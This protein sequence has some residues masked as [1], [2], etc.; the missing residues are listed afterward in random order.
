MPIS[1]NSVAAASACASGRSEA[2]H[3]IVF[4]RMRSVVSLRSSEVVLH[5]CA[6]DGDDDLAERTYE[7][8]RPVGVTIL[9]VLMWIQAILGMVSGVVFLLLR[10]NA[11]LRHQT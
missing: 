8:H 4:E 6:V 2:D 1:A 7:H 3:T 11:T 5:D 10:H 9:I